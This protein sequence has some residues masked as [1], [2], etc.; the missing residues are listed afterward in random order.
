[1]K[2]KDLINLLLEIPMDQEICI[3]DYKKTINSLDSD[4]STSDGIYPDF[5]IELGENFVGLSFDNGEEID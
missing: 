2:N 3:W 1:M 5:K 4:D